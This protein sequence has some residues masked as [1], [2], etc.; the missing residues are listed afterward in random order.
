MKKLE[1]EQKVITLQPEVKEWLEKKARELGMTTNQ[2]IRI[3]IN[4]YMKKED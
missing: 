4:D 2:L 1:L 3:I